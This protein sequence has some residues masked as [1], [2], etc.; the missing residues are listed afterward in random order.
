MGAPRTH[1]MAGHCG[2]VAC[3]QPRNRKSNRAT[4][5]RRLHRARSGA[6]RGRS[7]ASD[8]PAAGR[9]ATSARRVRPR[10]SAVARIFELPSHRGAPARSEPERGAF[11]P[12]TALSRS[13]GTG[14]VAESSPYPASC[15]ECSAMTVFALT[16]TLVGG[17]VRWDLDGCCAA[18]GSG[19]LA[20]ADV[21][22]GFADSSWMPRSCRMSCVKI[23]AGSEWPQGCGHR[24]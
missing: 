11:S 13:T 5:F 20:E 3:R 14:I 23:L 12:D 24:C 10:P 18:C 17:H 1:R 9:P 19:K 8:E 22:R 2:I 6:G 16:Q 15:M 4:A 7:P 21:R